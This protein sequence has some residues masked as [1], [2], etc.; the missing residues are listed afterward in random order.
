MLIIVPT[1]LNNKSKRKCYKTAFSFP[2][3]H[4]FMIHIIHTQF[5]LHLQLYL[6]QNWNVIQFVKNYV[7][8][9]LFVPA[10]HS[11]LVARWLERRAADREVVGSN[12]CQD[13]QYFFLIFFFNI[14]KTFFDTYK[15][16]KY[17]YW[18]VNVSAKWFSF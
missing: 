9:L 15:N 17:S 11:V 4:E 12:L 3:V 2:S 1:F 16:E 10:K 6:I 13:I 18:Y 7:Y 14:Y 8:K 5:Q